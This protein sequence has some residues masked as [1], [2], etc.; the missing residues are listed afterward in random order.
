MGYNNN[1]TEYSFIFMLVLHPHLNPSICNVLNEVQDRYDRMRMMECQ[2]ESR[3]MNSEIVV[4]KG[5]YKKKRS[6]RAKKLYSSHEGYLPSI[7][8][9]MLLRNKF[10]KGN[11][12]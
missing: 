4:I 9:C 1:V 10:S 11:F 5:R 2:E 8:K 3:S 6:I 7:Y 12:S